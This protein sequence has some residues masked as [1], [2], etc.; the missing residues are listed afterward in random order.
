MS[1]FLF[2]EMPNIFLYIF[3]LEDGSSLDNMKDMCSVPNEIARKSASHQLQWQQN[4]KKTKEKNKSDL[5]LHSMKTVIAEKMHDSFKRNMK[6]V[7]INVCVRVSYWIALN[8]APTSITTKD[9]L[10]NY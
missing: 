7:F 8:C 2:H 4:K 1:I 10:V 6:S 5:G 9:Y 3:H